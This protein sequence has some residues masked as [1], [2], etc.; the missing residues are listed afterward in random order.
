VDGNVGVQKRG[1][2]DQ[3]CHV[4]LT[5]LPPGQ[6]QQL[7]DLGKRD[8]PAVVVERDRAIAGDEA[9]HRGQIDQEG[10]KILPAPERNPKRMLIERSHTVL[11]DGRNPLP[12]LL[13]L[14][15][16]LLAAGVGGSRGRRGGAGSDSL[17][18]FGSC[19]PLDENWR[20]RQRQ[21]DGTTVRG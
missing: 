7:A 19:Q 17:L 21:Q 10:S 13:K 6:V 9:E 18:R 14:R 2:P 3:T 20:E 16:D 1:S 5:R 8:D 15:G 12:Q 11:L 4:T